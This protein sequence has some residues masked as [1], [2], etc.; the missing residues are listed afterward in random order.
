[1]R[2]SDLSVSL[3]TVPPGSRVCTNGIL[4]ASSNSTIKSRLV[5]FPAPSPPSKVMNFPSELNVAISADSIDSFAFGL[6]DSVSHFPRA[7]RGFY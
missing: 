4:W 6:A 1:M 3:S 5:D 7:Q 2:S